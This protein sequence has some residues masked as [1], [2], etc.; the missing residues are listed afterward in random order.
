MRRSY[1]CKLRANGKEHLLET[2][3]VQDQVIRRAPNLNSLLRLSVLLTTS[4]FSI[5]TE[6]NGASSQVN[7]VRIEAIRFRM[8][9]R[10][11]TLK[12]RLGLGG[13]RSYHEV[14]CI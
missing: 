12:T 3:E 6:A 13:W 14:P 11:R 4:I 8:T 5:I 7:T 2:L 9:F 1:A 10:E